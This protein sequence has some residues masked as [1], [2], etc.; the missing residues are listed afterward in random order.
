MVR[1]QIIQ[2]IQLDKKFESI[3]SKITEGSNLENISKDF[4]LQILKMLKGL[5]LN[6]TNVNGIGNNFNFVGTVKFY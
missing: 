4:Q 6:N 1:E 5:I 2:N 3:Q